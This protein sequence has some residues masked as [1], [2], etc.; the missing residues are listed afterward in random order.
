MITDNNIEEHPFEPFIPENISKLIL[1]SFP[2]MEQVKNKLDK[3]EWFY[4]AQDNQFWTILSKVYETDLSSTELKQEL[5]RKRG[6]GITDIFIKVKRKKRSNRDLY[7]YDVEYNDT[8]ISSILNNSKPKIILFTSKYVE[9]HFKK[10]F[11]EVNNT[12]CLPS[13]SGAA[14]IPISK[15]E[16]YKKYILVNPIGNT[17][18]YRVSK[19]K[20]LLEG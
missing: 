6:I 18:T 16:D 15:S 17:L 2:G 13:P 4:T 19:Y 9:K 1:G 7:L 5:F 10:V 12:K 14:N 8:K 3:K 11:P 20:E